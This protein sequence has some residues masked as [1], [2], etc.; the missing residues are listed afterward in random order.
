M[1]L[2][3]SGRLD[4]GS[5]YLESSGLGNSVPVFGGTLSF[6]WGSLG[7]RFL[8]IVVFPFVASARAFEIP[9]RSELRVLVQ[10]KVSRLG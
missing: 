5:S 1:T 7:G 2:S 8:Y 9:H 3:Y 4:L 6:C 10:K